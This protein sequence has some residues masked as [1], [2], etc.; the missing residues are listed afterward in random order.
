MVLASALLLLPLAAPPQDSLAE[1]ALFSRLT[2]EE[3]PC[4]RS[5]R[6]LVQAPVRA[7]AEHT[8]SVTELYGPWIEAAANAIDNEYGIPN[9]QE[10]QAKEPLNVVILGS[11]PSYKNAQR[12]V[13]HPTDDY[14]KAVFVEPPGIVTT[15]W[16]RSLRRA[17]AHELRI[18]TLR[19]ATR[20]LLKA[21]QAVETPLEPW[22]LAGIPAFIVHHGPDA[23]PESLAHPAPWEAAL[24]RLRALVANDEHRERFLIPLAELIDCPGPKEAAELGLKHA[25]LADIE[26]PY[27]PYDLPGSEIFTEQAALWVHFF[28]QGHAGR[29][30]ENFRNYVAKA[31][32]ANGGSEPMM[33]T[34]G[35]G[36]LEELDTPFLAHMNMLLGG[37][38]IALPEIELA[39]RA[40]VHHAG[41]L[42]E[43]WSLDG[44]RIAALARAINGDLEGAIMELEKASLESTDPPLRRGLLEEQAR[45]MQAQNMRRK[46]IASLLDSS[47]KLRLT[48]GEES[49]SVALERF[50]DDVLYFKPGRTDL[51]QLPIGQLAPGDVVRSMG[52]RAGEHGPGWV[53]AYLALLNQDERWDRKFDREADGAAELEQALK[54]GLGQRIQAAHLHAHLHTLAS[55]PAPTAPFEAEALLALCR[56]ATE[57]DRSN[58][59]T[60]DLW[61][62]ARPALAQVARSCWSFLFDSA[63]AEG[64]VA[65]PITPL[66]GGQVRLTYDFN[67]PEEVGD[68]VPAGDYLL[69]RS[70]ELFKLE[71]QTSTLAV[72]GGEWRGRGHAVFRHALVLQPPLR[73][74]YELVYGR[75]RPGKGLESTVFVGI[76][77]DGEGNYVGAWDL[78]DLEAI[79]I[80]SRRI[81]TDYEEGERTL[82]SAKPYAIELRHDGN[83]AEL[84]VDGEAKKKVAA[85]AR[86]SGALIFLVHSEV[87]VSIRRLEIEG[88]LDPEAMESARELW[89]AGQVRGM[90]L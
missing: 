28:H 33:L 55:T 41:I 72:A 75:P 47:R 67:E 53:A 40:E 71:S 77:D 6:L 13:P 18:P 48:R 29:H 38:L 49:V 66:E 5:V 83:H 52:N 16:D 15:H 78:F 51:E 36:K 4:H 88:T 30:R 24:E 59:L 90:G 21:Y 39:P 85:D 84:W 20:E 32:H 65:V 74:R 56:E 22:L 82:K 86:T 79:D 45:L 54:E 34:L 70:Q 73:V 87:T 8:A 81:E 27:H 10:S 31:L 69:D 68:F 1:H 17:P 7:D 9:L 19:L 58:P 35:L 23:T 60:A 43:T 46:F 37:N 3:I 2:L 50:S 26:L 89:V 57:L 12:Y 25:R 42:P 76:C 80:P 11:K 63:G 61:E 64:L 44:L 14:E 62:S